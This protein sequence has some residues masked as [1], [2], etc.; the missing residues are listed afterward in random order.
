MR[1]SRERALQRIDSCR[2]QAERKRPQPYR[3]KNPPNG[4]GFILEQFIHKSY[5]LSMREF[6]LAICE[7]FPSTGIPPG[8]THQAFAAFLAQGIDVLVGQ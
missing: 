7:S 3:H 8:S 5:R 2:E 4:Q 1:G 6:V